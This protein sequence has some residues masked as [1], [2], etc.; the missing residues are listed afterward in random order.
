MVKPGGDSDPP[1]LSALAPSTLYRLAGRNADLGLL[2]KEEIASGA[3]FRMV[4]IAL[5]DPDSELW[6]YSISVGGTVIAGRAIE[7]LSVHRA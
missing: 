2:H 5:S 6:R 3:L 1:V 4:R 7:R